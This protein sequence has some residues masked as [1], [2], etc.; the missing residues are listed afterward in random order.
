VNNYYLVPFVS[1]EAS[2]KTATDP[3]PTT[4]QSAKFQHICKKKVHK[5]Q[6][7]FVYPWH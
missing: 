7:T 4:Y 2:L 3:V 5:V 6:K 1:E